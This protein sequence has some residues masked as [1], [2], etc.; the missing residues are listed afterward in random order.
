[1]Q[2]RNNLRIL[3]IIRVKKKKKVRNVLEVIVCMVV[4]FFTLGLITQS[5]HVQFKALSSSKAF[6]YLL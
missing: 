4:I 6:S 5:F 2:H 1:M 3:I